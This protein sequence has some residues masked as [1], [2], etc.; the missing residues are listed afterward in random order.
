MRLAGRKHFVVW[1]KITLVGLAVAAIA[2][3]ELMGV[4]QKWQDAVFYTVVVFAVA[5]MALRPAW[6]RTVFWRTLILVFLL[7][8]LVLIPIVPA[9]P[10]GSIGIP[11]L[12]LVLTGLIE[13]LLIVVVLWHRAVRSKHY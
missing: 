2:I 12:P 13:T 6:G 1:E 3:T 8:V 10:I 9:L 7:H 5:T 11:K 4:S